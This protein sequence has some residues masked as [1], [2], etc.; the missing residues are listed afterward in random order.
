M[1]V[2]LSAFVNVISIQPS[3]YVKMS[4]NKIQG[5]Y[6]AT[7]KEEKFNDVFR[8]VHFSPYQKKK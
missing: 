1:L 3:L 7:A 2:F 6:N 5:E 8:A 4:Y